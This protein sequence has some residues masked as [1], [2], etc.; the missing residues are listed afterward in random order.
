MWFNQQKSFT[1]V[2]ELLLLAWE[3][4][5]QKLVGGPE[6]WK[7]EST[8]GAPRGQFIVTRQERPYGRGLDTGRLTKI[9][10]GQ[11]GKMRETE[12]R[13][14]G[15]LGKKEQNKMKQK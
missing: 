10:Q 7:T 3:R 5:S 2:F 13:G 8:G 4:W 12:R 6:G 9:C 11:K 1:P 15:D 14:R